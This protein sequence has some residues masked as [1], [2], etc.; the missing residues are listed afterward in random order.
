MV[1]APKPRV[2]IVSISYNQELY[3]EQALRSFVE[4]KT[5]FAFE[6]IIADDCSTDNTPR[7]IERYAKKF[8]DIIKPVLR[9]E[10]VGVQR[11]LI[12]AL[13]RASGEYIALCEGDDYWSD[14]RKLQMQYDFL[15]THCEYSLCFHPVEVVYENHEKE[16]EIYPTIN[17]AERFTVK[18]LLDQNFIQ[19]NSVMYRREQYEDIPTDILPL[20]WYL[21][22]YHAKG[23]KIGFLNKVMSVYRRH[24]GGI[25]WDTYRNIEEIWTRHGVAHYSLF[26]EI[27]KLFA[28]TPQYYPIIDRHIYRTLGLL[29]DTDRKYHSD[30]VSRVLEE[31]PY[32]VDKLTEKLAVNLPEL[33]A[34]VRHKDDQVRRLQDE[35]KIIKEQLKISQ[36]ELLNIKTSR[37]WTIAS[38]IRSYVSS[39]RKISRLK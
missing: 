21:H 3:I 5:N 4:Q 6:V 17:D 16:S 7:I 8:P 31:Y 13:K 33:E 14:S 12:D 37:I 36:V 9:S 34:I 39:L 25:W 30:L 26:C 35:L 18:A 27:R 2:S 22:L 10:N 15:S 24:P 29:I 28:D 23:G 38:R 11:N 20:D 19:T 1:S 32:S